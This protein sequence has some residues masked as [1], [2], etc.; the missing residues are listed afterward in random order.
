VATR[1]AVTLTNGR[2]HVLRLPEDVAAEDAAD[3]LRGGR[4][5][6]EVG[7]PDGDAEW[8]RFD[9]GEGWVHRSAIAELELVSWY[10]EPTEL[11]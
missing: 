1:L 7:W 2:S 6:A 4:T 9:Q 3:V 8:L 5:G 10:E 11:Y